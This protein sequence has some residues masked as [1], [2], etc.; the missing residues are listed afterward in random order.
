MPEILADYSRIYLLTLLVF[1]I[2]YTA[3]FIQHASN[4]KEP[5]EFPKLIHDEAFRLCQLLQDQAIAEFAISAR[6][7]GLLGYYVGCKDLNP[8]CLSRSPAADIIPLVIL[9]QVVCSCYTWT[10]GRGRRLTTI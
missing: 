3:H 2:P 4:V 9:L 6:L 5:T 1:R 10:S 7:V 8:V